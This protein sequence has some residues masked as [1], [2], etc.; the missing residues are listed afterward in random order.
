MPWEVLQRFHLPG[1]V[2]VEKSGGS[3]VV[4]LLSQ[5]T[6]QVAGKCFKIIEMRQASEEQG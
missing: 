1:L 2:V 3:I 5:I 4:F 6:P